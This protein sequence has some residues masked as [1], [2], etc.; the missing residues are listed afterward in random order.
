MSF[1]EHLEEL[2]QRIIRS[3]LAVA[4]GFGVCFWFAEIIFNGLVQ[5]VTRVLTKLKMP[6]KLYFTHPADAFNV[7]LQI[8]LVA[9]I[10]LASPYVL[11]QVW[12]FIAPGLYSR[13]RKYAAPFIFFCS[14]LFIAG[15]AFGYFIAFPYALEFLLSLGGSHMTPWLTAKEYLDLF[16]TVILG[17]G[18]VFEMP[19]LIL[20]LSLLGIVTPGFLLRNFRYA[21]LVITIIAAIITPTT[22][23]TNLVI[24][25]VPMVGLYLLGAG[26]AWLVYRRRERKEA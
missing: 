13:E 11:Y 21:V 2:R 4:I 9:G 8:G 26:I 25:A 1:L 15:G 7:Y 23:V 5:P 10:F 19:V 18:L 6:D 3:L 12:G 14:G 17:L 16:T 24:F 22:D 20:F